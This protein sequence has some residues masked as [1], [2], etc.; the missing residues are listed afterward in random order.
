MV[1]V[2][3]IDGEVC[4][5]FGL[6]WFGSVFFLLLESEGRGWKGIEEI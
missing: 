3:V 5:W 6:V 4:C 1:L 2:V